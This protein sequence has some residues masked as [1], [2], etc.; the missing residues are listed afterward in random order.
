MVLH[1]IIHWYISTCNYED[2]QFF[3]NFKV[4]LFTKKKYLHIQRD[5]CIGWNKP[6]YKLYCYDINNDDYFFYQKTLTF[7]I[8]RK[9]VNIPKKVSEVCG[10]SGS[11]T[12]PP[13]SPAH[14]L[15]NLLTIIG[16]FILSKLFYFWPSVAK[17]TN[18]P[19]HMICTYIYSWIFFLQIFK[20]FQ[21][22]LPS[23]YISNITCLLVIIWYM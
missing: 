21:I 4:F 6:R 20:I 8:I 14:E 5:W 16:L 2:K 7:L 18:I 22:F 3:H 19:V 12:R 9:N 11:I 13:L 17:L 10:L 15:L 23:F 1:S